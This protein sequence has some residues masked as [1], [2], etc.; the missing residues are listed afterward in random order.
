MNPGPAAFVS[1]HKTVVLGSLLALFALT[2]SVRGGRPVERPFA[3]EDFVRIEPGEFRM[4]CSIGD[5]DCNET[6]NPPHLV[7]ISTHFEM[8]AH[9]VTEE[10]WKAVMGRSTGNQVSG[11]RSIARVSWN[12]VQKFLKKLNAKKDGFIYRLPTEAEWEYAARNETRAKD[13]PTPASFAEYGENTGYAGGGSRLDVKEFFPIVNG[14]L[15][16][17]DDGKLP[18]CPNGEPPPEKPNARNLY[19]MLGNLA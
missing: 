14:R 18:L 10:Q 1:R 4:G 3:E 19:N 7:Q 16:C 6:E 15:L 8:Q 13:S 17:G 9:Q 12:D 11:K 2:A 5:T